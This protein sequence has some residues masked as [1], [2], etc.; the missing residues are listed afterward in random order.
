MKVLVTGSS[1]FVGVYLQKELSNHNHKVFGLDVSKDKGALE[2]VD[3]RDSSKLSCLVNEINPDA[4]FHLAGI[5]KAVGE[6]PKE[7]YEINVMGTLNLLMACNRLAHKPKFMFVSSS[8][9]YGNVAI[10]SQPIMEN[11]FF[12]PLNHYGASKAA[13]ENL[14]LAYHNEYNLPVCILRP[15]NHTGPGQPPFFVLP[16][17]VKA[18]KERK[19]TIHLGNLDITRDFCDV[20]DVVQIYVSLLENFQNGQVFNIASGNGYSLS[21][22]IN[23]L[24]ELSGYRP[25]ILS[26]DDFK[27]SNDIKY[28]IGNCEKLNSVLDYKRLKYDIRYT[29]EEMLNE[30]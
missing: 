3:I 2:S 10:Y 24:V 7:I 19:E 9:V 1:G 29:L 22:I 30:P 12:S 27:R 4:V 13:G 16:K 21:D 15:F 14:V 18:F 6:D 8:Q 23:I 11:Q 26:C 17:L 25:K 20:R 5:S 28:A